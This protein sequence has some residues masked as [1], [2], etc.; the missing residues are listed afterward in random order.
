[1]K[2]V[3]EQREK[4]QKL[5]AELKQRQGGTEK[6]KEEAE[7]ELDK[8]KP[9]VEE[10]KKAVS[11]IPNDAIAEVKSFNQPPAPVQ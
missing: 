1:M 4:V 10:A 9:M 5:E 2:V 7:R 3:G 6:E 11:S 8:V